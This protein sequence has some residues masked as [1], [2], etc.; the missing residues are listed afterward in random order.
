[1]FC[2]SP[3]CGSTFSDVDT[4]VVSNGEIFYFNIDIQEDEGF[5]INVQQQGVFNLDIQQS[6]S[7]DFIIIR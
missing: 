1:M 3:I 5:S 7:E 4:Y 2:D 6:V